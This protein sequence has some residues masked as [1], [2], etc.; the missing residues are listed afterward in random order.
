MK[1]ASGDSPQPTARADGQLVEAMLAGD[2]ERFE[3]LVRRYQGV[4]FALALQRIGRS[5]AAE[6]ITQDVFVSVFR[7]LHQLKDAD[8]FGPWLRRITLRQCGM[9]L[10]AERRERSS[11]GLALAQSRADL[12]NDDPS[13]RER[14]GP[15][16]IDALIQELPEGLRA[17]AVLCL[18]DEMSPSAA[19]SV[20]DITPGA[21]R[22]RLHDARARLQRRI[23]KK[24]ERDLRLHLLPRD[25]A[26]RC[27]CRCQRARV[28]REEKENTMSDTKEK[29]TKES[30][31]KDCGCGCQGP[32]ADEAERQAA[33]QKNRRE[34]R[35]E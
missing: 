25:F 6:E 21:L 13:L 28:A 4:V 3:E 32:S 10:R 17:A 26:Q 15:L 16:D 34:E 30:G 33:P 27:V 35:E 9:W 7:S 23:V 31:D 29:K 19:A 20:L 22:K 24:A 12:V 18:E 11:R 14:E 2:R 1:H 5:L 8:R